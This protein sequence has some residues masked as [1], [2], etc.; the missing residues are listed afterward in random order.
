MVDWG[1]EASHTM[2]TEVMEDMGRRDCRGRVSWPRQRREQLLDEYERS[3]LTQATFARRE[4]VSYSTFAHWVQERRRGALA[5]RAGATGVAPRFV[6]VGVPSMASL[7]SELSVSLPDGMVI[8]GA[9]RKGGRWGESPRADSWTFFASA[10][11][12]SRSLRGRLLP[13]LPAGSG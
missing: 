12:A 1:M 3:G 11:D 5:T 4:S 2:E 7:V 13:A 6:E 10:S 8:R 9:D